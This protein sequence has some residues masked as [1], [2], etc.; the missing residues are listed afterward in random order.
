[1]N[2]MSTEA[3]GGATEQEGGPLWGRFFDSLHGGDDTE[4]AVSGSHQPD[5]SYRSLSIVQSPMSELHPNDSASVA[6]DEQHSVLEGYGKHHS[7]AL[8]SITGMS[9]SALPV[10]DG[11][12]VFKFRTPSGRTHRFQARQ[13]N[14]ENLRDI[15]SGKLTGDPF[16]NELAQDNDVKPDPLDFAI[17]YTDTDGDTVL[18]TSDNDVA[19][20]VK[21]ARSSGQDRVVLYIQGG[22][23]WASDAE[24]SAFKA[25]EVAAAAREEAKEI[26]KAEDKLPEGVNITEPA[27]PHAHIPHQE[28]DIFG[29]PKDLLLPASIAGLAAV[30]IGVFTIS[31]LTSR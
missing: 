11:T 22:K 27:H 5:T 14:V 2:N 7:G 4:S 26:A 20:A 18:I 13:D 30:I 1:M 25:A 9:P 28:E 16:F 31:R 10:D 8:P 21:I 3:A 19:D 15:I 23:G 12:Y 29:I 24:K 6:D 17:S